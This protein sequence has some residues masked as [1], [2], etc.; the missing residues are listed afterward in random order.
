M[1][2]GE[3]QRFRG[4]LLEARTR[5][6]LDGISPSESEALHKECEEQG[7]LQASS[8]LYELADDACADDVAMDDIEL[9]WAI[10]GEIS[11]ALNRIE[12]GTYGVCEATGK[13]LD[14]EAL[15]LRPWVRHCAEYRQAR[16]ESRRTGGTP[17]QSRP[18]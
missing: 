2:A 12:A 4:V 13:P 5:I 11:A 8:R 9:E 1:T 7:M 15:R 17:K 18:E 3:L 10:L 6:L 14:R 16:A